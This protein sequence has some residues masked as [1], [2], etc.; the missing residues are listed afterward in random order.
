[1]PTRDIIVVGGSVGAVDVLQRVCAE[2]P[3]DL[4]AAVLV[5]VHVGMMGL[6]LLAGILDQGCPLHAVTASDGQII[7]PGTLYVAPANHHLLVLDGV[8][9]LG[10]GPRENM[11]R[12]A[13]DPLFRSAALSHG[14]RVIGVVL[15]GWL[16]D[17]AAGLAAIKHCGGITVVQNP[18]DARADEMPRSA[19]S[20]LEVDYRAAAA[21]LGSLLAKL[22]R[23]PAGEPLSCP[24]ELGVEVDIALGHVGDS[25][26]IRQLADPVPLSCPACGGVMS[27]IR[28]KRPLR[29]RCQVGHAYT[30]ET[31][32]E[33]KEGSTDEAL[34]VALRII[35]E[36][37]VLLEKMAREARSTG[38]ARSEA[39][40]NERVSELRRHAGTIRRAGLRGPNSA[41][42][43]E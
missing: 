32:A 39:L 6:D 1:V 17:G 41:K 29:F 33:E 38:R 13:I 2:L 21:D 37:A 30:A 10:R 35:E 18:L 4:P 40:F 15:S 26:A 23:E 43:A 3:A 36:R 9:R 16:N 5:V 19:L 27:E 20:T 11:A 22:A 28:D 24:P 25:A 34:R 14:P 12:P 42:A 8:T 7:Q 31:L